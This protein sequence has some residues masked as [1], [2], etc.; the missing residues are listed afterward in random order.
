MAQSYE[1]NVPIENTIVC[2]DFLQ[3]LVTCFKLCHNPFRY[4]SYL[5]NK[6]FLN[7]SQ[8]LWY[9]LNTLLIES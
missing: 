3:F 6:K 8:L 4:H 5:D 7:C 2:N 9:K 1:T